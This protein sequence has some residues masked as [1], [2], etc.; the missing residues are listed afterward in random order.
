MVD[1]VVFDGLGVSC[2]MFVVIGFSVCC[3]FVIRL[4]LVLVSHVSHIFRADLN[5]ARNVLIEL[6]GSRGCHENWK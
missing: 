6:E 2:L 5:Q 3:L 1:S 4:F